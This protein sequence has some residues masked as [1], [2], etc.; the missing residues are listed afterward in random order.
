VID[1][2]DHIGTPVITDCPT[3]VEHDGVR[4]EI[5]ADALVTRESDLRIQWVEEQHEFSFTAW[6]CAYL[7]TAMRTPQTLFTATNA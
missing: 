1:A 6:Q 7:A 4:Y 3:Y 2:C 5:A